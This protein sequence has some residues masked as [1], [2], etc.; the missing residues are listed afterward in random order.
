MCIIKYATILGLLISVTGVAQAPHPRIWLD[1]SVNNRL[2]KLVASQDPSWVALKA[3]ADML[4]T[5][6]VAPYSRNAGSGICYGC[7]AY[8]NGGAYAGSGWSDS[9]LTL[10][11]AYQQ[12]GNVAYAKKV[13]DI[14]N[15]MAGAGITPL[16]NDSGYPSRTVVVAL[17]IGYDWIYDQL[18][19]DDIKNYTALLTTY[20]TWMQFSTAA[21]AW[22]GNPNADDNYYS[23][24]IVG[25]GLAGLAMEGD[26]P[27]AISVQSKILESFSTYLSGPAGVFQNSGAGGYPIESYNYGQNSFSRFIQYMWAMKTA[28]KTDLL[29][30]N[31]PWIRTAAKSLIYNLKPDMW[32][33]TDEGAFSGSFSKILTQNYPLLLSAVLSQYEAYTEGQWM[34]WMLANIGATP[35]TGGTPRNYRPSVFEAFTYKMSVAPWSYDDQPLAYFSPGDKHLYVRKDWNKSSVYMTF[36]GGTKTTNVGNYTNHQNHS[37]GH[38]SVQRAS[39]YLLIGMAN[40]FGANGITGSPSYISDGGPSWKFNTMFYWDG[41]STTTG[42]CYSQTSSNG[43]YAGCQ[44]FW[45]KANTLTHLETDT[46]S[47]SKAD[48]LPAYLNS[49]GKTSLSAYY[50]TFLDI[51]GD[52]AFVYDRVATT[53]PSS[54]RQLY[55]HTPALTTAAVPG[56]ATALSISGSTASATVGNSTIWIKTLLPATATIGT[57]TDL[58]YWG[59]SASMGTQHFEISDPNAST[60]ANTV[61]LTVIAPTD[62][63]LQSMPSTALIDGGAYKGAIYDDGATARVGLLSADGTPQTSATYAVPSDF[64]KPGRHVVLELKPGTYTVRKDGIVLSK[65]IR[66]EDNG[67]LTFDGTGA[68]KYSVTPQAA[69]IEPE[70]LSVTP[71]NGQGAA[72]L[73]TLAVTDPAGV[74]DIASVEL[75]IGSSP[76]EAEAC[77]VTY[78]T[79]RKTFSLNNDNGAGEAGNLAANQASLVSNSQCTL[80]GTGSWIQLMRNTL[81]V[82][83]N[84]AFSPGFAAMGGGATKNIYAKP[85][86]AAG[87]APSGG[88][89]NAGTWLV[90]QF[91]PT[92]SALPASL[93]PSSGQGMSQTFALTAY[94]SAGVGDLEAV[95]L[96]ISGSGTFANACWVTYFPQRRSFGLVNDERTDYVGFVS[97]GQVDSVPTNSQCVLTGAGS[98]VQSSGNFLTMNFSIQFQTAFANPGPCGEAKT[99]YSYLVS[100]GGTTTDVQVMGNWRVASS[101]ATFPPAVVSASNVCWNAL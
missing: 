96:M 69:N 33:V 28:G 98:T 54:T 87:I 58:T 41:G 101:A 76:A 64:G 59:S 32:S 93:V 78:N 15:V 65:S 47:F 6:T 39:D 34:Q 61:F 81:L 2:S 37:A 56:N 63:G 7:G 14:L 4:L 86:T 88:A 52:L 74:A 35:L 71:A 31:S 24:Y 57:A 23:G 77:A 5:A 73:F 97:P 40:W 49:A 83:V 85:M 79:Q 95:H 82:N 89:V 60:S 11:M 92:E 94:D 38:V 53:L 25:F 70:V 46:Y 75:M 16:S 12:T 8:P 90:P 29:A 10:S 100:S 1:A 50:R 26:T 30:A 68:G 21:Y 3:N 9:I 91:S 55:W 72:Q 45:G 84:L 44:M 67:S 99:V 20:W 48:L 42:Q 62:A 13:K 27:T 18:S 17:A 19:P 80:I 51:G 43:Q 22:S 66:V 36:N